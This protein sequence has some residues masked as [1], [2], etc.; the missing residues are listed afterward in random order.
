MCNFMCYIC[1]WL[2]G[3]K[4]LCCPLVV[5]PNP[6]WWSFASTMPKGGPKSDRPPTQT[7]KPRVK[8]EKVECKQAEEH[9]PSDEY[10]S[11]YSCLGGSDGENE[12]GV[13]AV[14]D[15]LEADNQELLQKCQLRDREAEELRT[16]VENLKRQLKLSKS[17]CISSTSMRS[18]ICQ[19]IHKCHLVWM[20]V[21]HLDSFATQ[22]QWVGRSTSI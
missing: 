8:N 13:S 21:P 19:C 5:V 15:D 3:L 7:P 18:W 17:H 14:A 10:S 1:T 11:S 4:L 16:E 2:F 12:N 6:R 22:L 20:L 9:L